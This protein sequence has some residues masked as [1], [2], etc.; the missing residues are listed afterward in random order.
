MFG[1][2][3]ASKGAPTQSA[4]ALLEEDT[5]GTGLSSQ[6]TPSESVTMEPRVDSASPSDIE[7]FLT[8]AQLW[9]IVA[10]GYAGIVTGDRNVMNQRITE[11]LILS[12]FI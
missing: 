4:R 12:T 5:V 11:N 9:A 7:R 1:Q 3:K 10:L 2:S 8:L 6:L